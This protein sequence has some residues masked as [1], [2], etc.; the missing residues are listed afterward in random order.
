MPAGSPNYSASNSSRLPASTGVGLVATTRVPLGFIAL[1]L[2]SLSG[3]AAWLAFRPEQLSLPYLHP[4]VAALAH[5]WLPGFLL[6]AAMGAIYQL[7]PVV[8]GAPLRGGGALAWIHLGVHATGLVL[9]IIG[10]GAGRFDW[11]AA[12]GVLI[13][14][15]VGLLTQSVWRTFSGAKRRDAIAWS[16]PLSVS[17]LGVTVAV[18]VAL[19]LNR[20]WPYL[21]PSPV[22]LLHAHAHLGLAGFFLTLLQGATFQLVPMFT[23][24]ELRR[25]RLVAAGLIVTQAGM[26]VLVGGML[27]QSRGVILGGATLFA[28]GVAFSG[29][30][31]A[32]TLRARRK[33]NL[34]P[35]VLAFLVGVVL[36]AFSIFGGAS[37]LFAPA[38]A[39]SLRGGFAYGVVVIGGGLALGLLGMLCKIIPFLIWMNAYGQRIGRQKVPSATAL[40]SP[41]LER[42][43]LVLHLVALPLLVVATLTGSHAG[44]AAG[45]W[46][47]AFGIAVFLVN[48]F[49]VVSHAWH[50]QTGDAPRVLSSAVVP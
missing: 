2:C 45:A 31:L 46:L 14:A 33:R 21:P 41:V 5:L 44:A 13:S 9:L 38:G 37:L 16:F 30:A 32:A 10:F 1:G 7:M 40:A 19:A 24:G 3:A 20:R 42:T 43:W 26:P 23:L 48:A 50:P 18:G 39:L 35:G 36:L 22:T 47:Y 25:P 49:R 6:S 29:I 8:L 12:G 17:W 15:G 11:V 34:E 4:H 28:L 27:F